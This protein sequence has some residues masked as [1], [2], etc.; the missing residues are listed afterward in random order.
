MPL[1]N[2]QLEQYRQDA[3]ESL[4]EAIAALE[5]AYDLIQSARQNVKPLPTGYNM[6]GNMDAYVLNYIHYSPDS[7]VERL[8]GYI[9]ELNALEEEEEAHAE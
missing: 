4:R 5:N 1:T 9:E 2:D 8:E 7:L 3:I 6:P